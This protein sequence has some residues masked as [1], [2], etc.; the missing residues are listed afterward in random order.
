MNEKGD[1]IAIK[2]ILEAVINLVSLEFVTLS[3][4]KRLIRVMAGPSTSSG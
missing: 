2:F 1:F 4:S 3:L